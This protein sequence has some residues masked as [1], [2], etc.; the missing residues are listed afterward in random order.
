MTNVLQF[1]SKD[2]KL[3]KI[4]ND[5]INESVG[6]NP[7]LAKCFEKVANEMRQIIKDINSDP[8]TFQFTSIGISLQ[9][10]VELIKTAATN[11]STEYSKIISH[12]LTLL[13]KEKLAVCKALHEHS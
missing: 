9:D 5:A 13:L 7:E 3:N 2:V 4:I 12:V 11:M 8:P 6:D 1:P 10:N